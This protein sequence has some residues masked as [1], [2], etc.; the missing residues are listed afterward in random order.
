MFVP[1]EVT[2]RAIEAW[3]AATDLELASGVF[4][5]WEPATQS[6]ALVLPEARGWILARAPWARGRPVAARRGG[7]LPGI[8]FLPAAQASDLGLPDPDVPTPRRADEGALTVVCRGVPVVVTEPGGD[9]ARLAA[10]VFTSLFAAW[11]SARTDR[12][13]P[14]VP[15]LPETPGAAALAVVEGRLLLQALREGAR[16]GP[17]E[18]LVTQI[19]LVRRERWADCEP[20]Q[21]QDARAVECAAGL[22]RYAGACCAGRLALAARNTPAVPPAELI[23]RLADLSAE[24]LPQRGGLT[25]WALASLLH[26]L[27]PVRGAAGGEA[28]AGGRPWAQR[29]SFPDGWKAALSAGV[30]FDQVIESYV[31]LDGGSR[32]DAALVAA[33]ATY[34]HA[35]ALERAR[36]LA[37][38]TADARRALI[39]GILRGEGTLLA[40]DIRRLGRPRVESPAPVQAVHGG[41][42]VYP[43]GA[44][45][46]FEA[47]PHLCF[48]RLPV[49]EDRRSGLL[50]TRVRARLR[51]QGD[52]AAL[53]G[54]GRAVFTDG[55]DLTLPGMRLRAAGGTIE[56]VDGGYLLRLFR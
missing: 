13:A 2:A 14:Q 19:V 15:L 33:L 30:A 52:G 5:G 24:P 12:G 9:P 25:G 20:A 3:V 45:F 7:I 36:L 38:A 8:S 22:A 29:R 34:G 26:L 43:A 1:D 11:W 42:A 39:E 31:R 35:D 6:V 23:A 51:M 48:D 55:L 47:G 53:R 21:E 18:R 27:E 44:S 41:L 17:L 49:A 4:P 32:D 56:P 16:G 40:I 28:V 50:Q 46:A 37:A 10:G 54:G